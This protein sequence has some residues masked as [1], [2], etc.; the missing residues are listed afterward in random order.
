MAPGMKHVPQKQGLQCI[1]EFLDNFLG[2]SVW[3]LS[4]VFV[5][6]LLDLLECSKVQAH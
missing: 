3:S 2:G 4:P 6:L 5:S 1:F